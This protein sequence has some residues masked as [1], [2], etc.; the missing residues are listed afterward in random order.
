[1]KRILLILIVFAAVALQSAQADTPVYKMG[2]KD[3]SNGE[4]TVDGELLFYDSGGPDGAAS[5]FMTGYVTFK[6]KEAGQP[7]TIEFSQPVAFNNTD[8]SHL[9]VYDGSSGYP[10]TSGWKK[11][12]PEG[13]KAD[14]VN[15]STFSY[16]S[17]SGVIEV[18]Y[19]APSSSPKENGDGWAAKLYTAPPKPMEFQGVTALSAIAGLCYPGVKDCTIG[20]FD[21]KADGSLDP[22]RA[23]TISFSVSGDALTEVSDVRLLMDGK[24]FGQ[25]LSALNSQPSTISFI[26]TLFIGNGITEFRLVADFKADAVPGHKLNVQPTAAVIG[27]TARIVEALSASERTIANMLLM[28]AGSSIY[29]VGEAPV[30]FYDDGGPDGKYT[31]N[32]TGATTFLS[33]V[34]GKKVAVDFTSLAL[35]NNASA[36]SVGNNDVIRVYSGREAVDSCLLATIIQND[37]VKLYS[38]AADGS[39]TVTFASKTGYPT[40]GFEALVSLF[41][42]VAMTVK[43]A[44][45]TAPYTGTIAGGATES[46][47]LLDLQTSGTEPAAKAE[48]FSFSVSG[49]KKGILYALGSDKEAAGSKIGEAEMAD[50]KLILS[51]IS[52]RLSALG[53]GHN[54]F[55]LELTA[56]VD[57][58]NGDEISATAVSV[59]V[60]GADKNFDLSDE[61]RRSVLNEALS[62]TGSKSYTIYG[63]WQFRNKPSEYSYYGYDADG[64]Q[65]TTFIP[66]KE[67]NVIE[68][69][70]SKL[71]ITFPS[72]SYG[73]SSDPV[74]KVISGPSESGP[75]LYE[76]T[77]DTKAV[78]PT[79]VFSSS[80][81]SGA[82]TIVFDTKSTRGSSGAGFGATMRLYKPGP[83]QVKSVKGFQPALAEVAPG[84]KD[85]PAVGMQ[86]TTEGNLEPLKLTS[87]KVNLK[88]CRDI[89][90]AVK[91]YTTGNRDGFDA[92]TTTLLAA[93]TVVASESVTLSCDYTLPERD[94]Y[95]Y[96]TYDMAGTLASDLP[97]DASIEQVTIGG[98]NPGVTDPDPQ[99]HSLTKNIYLFRGND[100]VVTVDG[101]MMFYDDGGKDG[102]YTTDHKG[103]VTFMPAEGKILK[104]RFRSF[105]TNVNDDFE[106]Y[107]GTSTATADRLVRLYSSKTDLPD[108]MSTADNGALTVVFNP[109]KN[110]INDGWEIE[111]QAFTP[112]PLNVDSIVVDSVAPSRLLRGSEDNTMLHIAVN[113]SGEKGDLD[114]SKVCVSS[115]ETMLDGLAQAT[116]YYTGTEEAFSTSRPFG[117]LES[118]FQTLDFTGEQVEKLPGTYHFYVAYDIKP[119]AAVGESFSASLD[120]IIISG[121]AYTPSAKVTATAAVG[122]AMRGRYVIG[123]SADADFPTFKAATDAI[124]N[125]IDGPVVLEVED[126]EYTEL[127]QLDAVPGNSSV[128]TLTL[129]SLSGD[130]DRVKVSYADYDQPGAFGDQ[131]GVLTLN[132]IDHATVEG[133]TFTT[134][135]TKFDAIVYIKGESRNDTIRNCRVYTETTS[136][137][138]DDINL[139]RTYAA[140][141]ANCN[142]DGLVVEGNLFEGGYIGTTVGGTTSVNLP[143][144]RGAVIRNNTYLNQGSK[145]IYISGENDALITGNTVMHTGTLMGTGYNAMDLYRLNGESTVAGNVIDV[146]DCK[147]GTSSYGSNCVGIYLRDI[148]AAETGHRLIYNNDIR[149]NGNTANTVLNTLYGIQ[150][151]NNDTVRQTSCFL[152]NTVVVSGKAKSQSSAFYV[153]APMGGSMVR[154]NLFQAELAAHA[155][156]FQK[157][158]YIGT[159]VYGHNNLWSVDSATVG[160]VGSA[161]YNFAEM[162]ATAHL[163]ATTNEKAEFLD[164]SIHE[165]AAPGGLRTGVAVDYVTTDLNG[166]ARPAVNTTRGA[167]EYADQNVAPVMAEGYP[168]VSGITSSGAVVSI[169]ADRTSQAFVAVV[170]ADGDVPTATEIQTSTHLSILR[171]N[172]VGT[173]EIGGLMAGTRY[174]AYT[175]ARS[176]GGAVS[177]VAASQ[178]FVTEA[179]PTEVSTF[180]NSFPDSTIF[181]D[182]TAR[183]DGFKVVSCADG[184]GQA[185]AARV[186]MMAGKSASVK[187]TN[188]FA[189]ALDGFFMLNRRPVKLTSAVGSTTLCV[190][191]IEPGEWRYV[192]IRDMGTMSIL[193]FETADADT[194]LIDDFSGQPKPFAADISFAPESGQEGSQARLIA[195]IEGGAWPYTIEW[196]DQTGKVIGTTSEAS[197]TLTHSMA[198]TLSVTDAWGNTVGDKTSIRVLGSLYPATF[199]DLAL[200][201]GKTDWHGDNDG[202]SSF[203][204]GSWE[205][206]NYYMP[207]YKAWAW[208]GYS[209]STSTAYKGIQDQFNNVVGGGERSANYGVVFCDSYMGPCQAL[210]SNTEE[211]D[212]VYGISLTNSAWVKDAILNGD[213]MSTAEGGFKQGDWLKLTLTATRADNTTGTRDIYLADYRDEDA[214]EHYFLDNWE[215]FD[216]GD[217][218]KVTSIKFTMEGTKR[219]SFGLTTPQ[220]VMVDNLGAACV[221]DT[222]PVQTIQL[223]AYGARPAR[224]RL[225]SLLGLDVNAAKIS[226]SLV[227]PASN[228]ELRDSGEVFVSGQ[229]NSD[230]WVLADVSQRGHTC[231]VAIPVHIDQEVGVDVTIDGQV[232]I[233]PVPA[234]ETLNVSV[235]LDGYTV[236]IYSLDGRLA[237]RFP[238]CF[239]HA[240]ISLDGIAAGHYVVR[241]SHPRLNYTKRIVVSK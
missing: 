109:S 12:V 22:M 214:R 35:F 36:I 24:Q 115:P 131:Y 140:D 11:P 233:W 30:N 139:L 130:R 101:S 8:D 231:R 176:Y 219:N 165:L 218:G 162:A 180:E 99:G 119:G 223:H 114:F 49:A 39:L 32:F 227:N 64:K 157:Y 147:M 85:N 98:A 146:T 158:D 198:Y 137:Y 23:T 102:K 87:L 155:L 54:Y 41:T 196:K 167:Y 230:H 178:P 216:L 94:S 141:R 192:S 112:K 46:F 67:G 159:G 228:I 215:W 25:A 122:E 133:I 207:D 190:K 1:M 80:D 212:T 77:K 163:L 229:R 81:P 53:Q 33:G 34:E 43:T 72:Y 136:S 26:D 160:C 171:A 91:L 197:P 61:A 174:I 220:Y 93:D 206:P 168:R 66:G 124:R 238:D 164:P 117:T 62:E 175:V 57:A 239:G 144:E 3:G 181:D 170:E 185:P 74:L 201:E 113:V 2:T 7:L 13:Y 50:G 110:N 20:G 161:D 211:G 89:V 27:D 225:A 177:A 28:S 14:L 194:V 69:E 58:R 56:P 47:L 173:V 79:A 204:S 84:S 156:R 76:M 104:F 166:T 31:Q 60:N 129:R 96:V 195:S 19:Y 184:P 90:K 83:M 5:G 21:T 108:I 38:T 40:D 217:L 73:S 153:N 132:G 107:N 118:N 106:V 65:V 150:V 179:A 226:Y 193:R 45:A 82:L 52:P 75:V 37:P 10:A 127:V 172:R 235:D 187:P 188:A 241:L 42:P 16:T 63:D 222:L 152:Y 142:N 224:L 59:K 15:G 6:A 121:I 203:F 100:D 68:M 145:G 128:N 103:K 237:G 17:P 44:S 123:K 200:P 213:G 9:Y 182:G 234:R 105:Y 111:I 126:G 48:S 151:A 183:F 154:N 205:L 29:T 95:F 208:F 169:L 70:F 134:S 4:Q 86:V 120:S 148:T 55:R 209:S 51:A 236:D 78:V 186:A 97:V 189:I 149:L 240:T 125:G 143:R 116:V 202:R 210:L 92:S 138:S 191:T 221:R 88:G 71:N 135:N 232:A 18:L 199:D